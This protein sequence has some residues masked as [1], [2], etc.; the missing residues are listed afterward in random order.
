MMKRKNL[1][2]PLPPG[3]PEDLA[4]PTAQDFHIEWYEDVDTAFNREAVRIIAECVLASY[5][6]LDPG[7][8]L[9]SAKTHVQYLQ[10][11]HRQRIDRSLFDARLESQRRVT[12]KRQ[13]RIYLGIP[14]F[15]SQLFSSSEVRFPHRSYNG[16]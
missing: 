8:V 4:L 11:R 15:T 1:H 14:A 13:V 6:R 7:S 10:K 3:P 16:L 9:A 5:P 2:D 12:R